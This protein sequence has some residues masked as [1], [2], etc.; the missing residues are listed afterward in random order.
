MN[1]KKKL[2]EVLRINKKKNKFKYKRIKKK[3]KVKMMLK[4]PKKTLEII[5]FLNFK[6]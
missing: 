6:L 3:I 2:K 5:F 4:I 1:K